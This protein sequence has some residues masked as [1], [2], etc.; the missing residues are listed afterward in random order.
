[1]ATPTDIQNASLLYAQNTIN[2]LNGFITD[3]KSA[4]SQVNVDATL[5]DPQ[6]VLIPENFLWQTLG[7]ITQGIPVPPA[8]ENYN[9][10]LT[11]TAPTIATFTP[12]TVLNLPEFTMV[13][14]IINIPAAPS[15]VLPGAP[16]QAPEI[17]QIA[18][19]N[20]PIFSLPDVPQIVRVNLPTPP[21]MQLPSFTSSLPVDDL[22][23]PSNV[24]DWNEQQY[25]SI[26]KDEVKKKLLNDILNGGY[27]IDTNDELMI[28]E[29]ARERELRNADQAIQEVSRR[30]AALGHMLPPGA[31][32]AQIEQAQNDA[33]GKSS[34]LS[35]EQAIKRAD[36]FV[37]NRKFTIQQSVELEK[38]LMDFFGTVAERALNAAKAQVE[39]GI[40]LFNAAIARYNVKLETYKTAA[41]VY[42]TQIRGAVAALEG[43]KVQVE[44]A[45][46]E[47]DVQK[48]YADIYATQIDGVKTL[49]E[50]YRTEME[51][52]QVQS[53]IE[54]LKLEAFRT[55][56]DAYTAQV[57]ARTAEF[58]MFESR[59][60]GETA[61]ITA[62]ESSVK[63]YGSRVEAYKSRSQAE[64]AVSKVQ[65]AQSTA[66]LEQYKTDM[67][68]YRTDVAKVS[69]SIKAALGKYDSQVRA[70]TAYSGAVGK[71]YDV[72]LEAQR[73]NASIHAEA[74][75]IAIQTATTRLQALL[76]MTD[77]KI[78]ATSDGAK[79][80]GSLA[81]AAVN[82]VVG[83]TSITATG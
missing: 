54:K 51:A 50:M 34:T 7:K 43:Y 55:S 14:P 71:A 3:L 25:V 15:G 53:S 63:A 49:I 30:A 64:E 79:T 80:L 59:I 11:P 82:S 72:N 37:E 68:R 42:E 76:K 31:L 17:A 10:I 4:I 29:R 23:A 9:G 35:R 60:R 74:S 45:K 32:F 18:L 65:I 40:S 27:G 19:P 26:L 44:A 22:V 83:L 66:K 39:M 73:A 46:L 33:L 58:Q 69:E 20:K 5:P 52:A 75:R 28:W 61:K 6:L 16:G 81:A 56:V 57:G 13:E 36:L 21:A 77:Q 8:L 24:F 48:V 70:Y 78:G 12:P 2:Q 67:E 38:I 47:A 62:F 41:N 1:M